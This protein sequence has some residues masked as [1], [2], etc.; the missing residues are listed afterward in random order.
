MFA[1]PPSRI[2]PSFFDTAINL[3]GAAV[4][5]GAVL[6]ALG[7]LLLLSLR[8]NDGSML[9]GAFTVANFTAAVAD[10]LYGR[11]VLR[12]LIIATAVTSTLR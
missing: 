6:F 1:A 4:A 2:R 12:S 9:G 11:V 8:T 7:V 10:P 3:P 5:L